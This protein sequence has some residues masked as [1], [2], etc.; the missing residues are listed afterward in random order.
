MLFLF[1]LFFLSSTKTWQRH[2]ERESLNFAHWLVTSNLHYLFNRII[3]SC[4]TKLLTTTTYSL[5]LHY[6]NIN[7]SKR[8][9]VFFKPLFVFLV[10]VVVVIVITVLWSSLSSLLSTVSLFCTLFVSSSSCLLLY[11]L[12][13]KKCIILSASLVWCFW[14]LLLLFFFYN[15]IIDWTWT[16]WNSYNKE[17]IINKKEKRLQLVVCLFY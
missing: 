12:Y 9:C 2:W 10:V 5:Y 17:N 6:T 15:A 1:V 11:Y 14:L 3:I 13:Y 7:I 16:R 4:R 8:V